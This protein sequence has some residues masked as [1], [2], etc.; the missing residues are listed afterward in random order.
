MSGVAIDR[1]TLDGYGL[2]VIISDAQE[3]Y[4]FPLTYTRHTS[5]AVNYNIYDM[6]MR[7]ADTKNSATKLF[8]LCE[9]AAKKK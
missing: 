7:R 1:P 5:H 3:I 4:T 2:T 8:V 6:I 9:N